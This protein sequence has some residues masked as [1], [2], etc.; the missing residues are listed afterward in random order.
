MEAKRGDGGVVLPFEIST[1]VPDEYE[2][3][4]DR[5]FDSVCGIATVERCLPS[6]GLGWAPE[7]C[8]QI[9]DVA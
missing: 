3:T 2:R 1:V 4:R 9:P 7:N 8:D 6:S 5:H